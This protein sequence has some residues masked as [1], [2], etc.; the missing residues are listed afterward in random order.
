MPK[1]LF[2]SKFQSLDINLFLSC[3]SRPD[4]QL[5]ALVYKLVPSL[6]QSEYQRQRAFNE[7][8]DIKPTSAASYP[9][10]RTK[11]ASHPVD[12]DLAETD[13]EIQGNHDDR[14]KVA[15]V[16]L[17]S[18]DSVDG[19]EVDEEY[20]FLSADDPIR[21]VIGF[22][23]FFQLLWKELYL[24]SF[25][26]NSFVICFHS[27]SLEYHPKAVSEH[28]ADR[29]PPTKYLQCPAALTVYHLQRFLASKYSLSIETTIGGRIDIQII[30]DDEVLP[31]T[32]TLMDIAY[33]S[34]WSQVSEIYL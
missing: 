21:W 4:P 1:H 33:C 14:M 19:L 32:F 31:K 15:R 24:K 25:Y 18:T 16:K 20:A 26:N 11:C 6:C 10:Q 17:C 29:I 12:D 30:S 3:E 13:N 9:P 23:L 28:E 8:H 5:K 34:K 2:N 7:K 22:T 27:L